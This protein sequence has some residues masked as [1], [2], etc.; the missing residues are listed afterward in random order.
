MLLHV[1][2]VRDYVTHTH[3]HTHTHTHTHAH[4]HTHTHA[5]TRT[6]MQT[7]TGLLKS[8][9]NIKMNPEYC[10]CV[11]VCVCVCFCL[12]LSLLGSNYPSQHKIPERGGGRVGSE[13]ERGGE[14]LRGGETLLVACFANVNKGFPCQQCTLVYSA[15]FRDRENA[16][17]THTVALFPRRPSNNTKQPLSWRPAAPVAL[18]LFFFF[19][20]FEYQHNVSTFHINIP[21]QNSI[22]TR[23]SDSGK[24][25]RW[26]KGDLL[27]ALSE[28]RSL[29]IFKS[30]K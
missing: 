30:N 22:S 3:A 15:E 12:F 4:T 27:T 23:R 9:R 25:Q 28:C 2:D 13:G 11:C 18:L 16:I 14:M 5:H 24:T 1:C 29:L 6:H 17:Y 7:H 20:W 26:L 19:R 21:Y 10:V 8:Q